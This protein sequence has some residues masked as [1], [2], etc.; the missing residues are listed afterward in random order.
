MKVFH[1]SSH[2]VAGGGITAKVSCPYLGCARRYTHTYAQDGEGVEEGEGIKGKGRGRG[3]GGT[4]QTACVPLLILNKVTHIHTVAFDMSP[5]WEWES[6]SLKKRSCCCNIVNPNRQY[7]GHSWLMRMW[8]LACVDDME[9]WTRP[10]VWTV[11]NQTNQKQKR[12]KTKLCSI[13]KKA[14]T[15]HRNMVTNE[16]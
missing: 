3:R 11:H 6:K 7:Q 9:W 15:K 14:W 1:N 5:S 8:M 16:T 12:N 10:L 13:K 2:K 4:L